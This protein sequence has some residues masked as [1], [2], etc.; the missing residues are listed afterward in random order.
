VVAGV[1]GLKNKEYPIKQGF[2]KMVFA[3]GNLLAMSLLSGNLINVISIF[4]LAI[5][6]DEISSHLLHL[7]INFDK[8]ECICFAS[9][10]AVEL[11]EAIK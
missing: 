7:D 6:Q 5:N 11:Y 4:G 8:G 9:E 3:T 2:N 1:V 10:E